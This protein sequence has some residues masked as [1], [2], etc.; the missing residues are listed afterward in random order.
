MRKDFL[1][2]GQP[3]IELDEMDEVLDSMRSAWLGTGPKVHQFEKEFADYKGIE[4]AAAVNS[5]TAALHLACLALGLGAGDEVI[6]TPMTFCAT[7]NAIIHSG[8]RPVLADIDPTTLNIDVHEI[9]K[10]ITPR[11]KALLIVHFAGRPS[12]M[13]AIADLAKFRNIKI[14]EDCAHAIESEYR[15]RKAGTI[16]DLGCFSFYATKNITT[17]EGG[18]IISRDESMLSR[19]KTMALHGLSHDAW[20]R[21]SDSG[22]KQYFVEEAG[23]KYNM[24]DLQA[25][26]GIHQ[27]RRI[28]EYW[29]RRQIIWNRYLEAFADLNI[30]LPPPIEKEIRH[31]YHLFTIRIRPENSGVSRDEFLKAMTERNIGVGVHYMSLPEHPYYQR[32]FSWRKEDFPEAYAFGRETV[33]LPISP[34]LTVQDT[35]DVISAVRSIILESAKK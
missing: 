8:A 1:V 32:T 22:Y 7:V 29:R 6:T 25:A 34:K 10:K 12:D 28:D 14:I 35:E 16:G 9:E 26:I 23:F 13:D 15:G 5:C 18:M 17:G 24:M 3:L 30:G 31:S 4:N 20:K 2:F 11:T 21:F 19:I 27:L 33:S